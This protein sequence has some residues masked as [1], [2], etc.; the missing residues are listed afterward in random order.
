MNILL[1][2]NGLIKEFSNVLPRF[3]ID[4]CWSKSCMCAYTWVEKNVTSNLSPGTRG[5]EFCTKPSLFISV[6][7]PFLGLSPLTENQVQSLKETSFLNG[8]KSLRQVFKEALPVG[9]TMAIHVM[10][11]S[12]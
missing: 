1:L 8:D 11:G 4:G 2:A 10:I 7:H 6:A 9:S 12:V 5:T 3:C